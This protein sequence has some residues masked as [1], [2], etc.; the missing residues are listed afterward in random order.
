MRRGRKLA[1]GALV[2]LALMCAMSGVATA[3]EKRL[4][5]YAGGMPL[6][7]GTPLEYSG[8]IVIV[9]THIGY[10]CENPLAQPPPE[11][12]EALNVFSN[13]GS[14]AEIRG[15]RPEAPC[16]GEYVLLPPEAGPGWDFTLGAK[17]N[18]PAA[19]LSAVEY[20]PDGCRFQPLPGGKTKNTKSGRLTVTFHEKLLAQ[21]NNCPFKSV[22]LEAILH[23]TAGGEPVEGIVQRS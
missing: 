3:A 6:A 17:G 14:S 15:W 8:E 10:G 18:G 11:E 7:T 21:S 9:T 19:A 1:L 16:A 4:T 2:V 22:R 5:L 13:G 20:V 12:T 23:F